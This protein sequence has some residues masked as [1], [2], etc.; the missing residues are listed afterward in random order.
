M[1]FTDTFITDA[2]SEMFAQALAEQG[3][4]IWGRAMTSNMN[5]ESLQPSAINQLT[6]I[7]DDANPPQYRYTSSGVVSNAVISI[8]D[9]IASIYC[10]LTNEQYS[11]TANTFGVWAK[12]GS[13]EYRLAII[14]R[15]G[16][17]QPTIVNQYENGI[18][19]IFVDFSL[20]VSATQVT[21]LTVESP[22]YARAAALDEE[23]Q[24]RTQ[25]VDAL[26]STLTSKINDN[27]DRTVTTHSA[28]DSSVG[29]NQ[30]ILGTK[31]FD[32]TAT[33]TSGIR[34]KPSTNISGRTDA[35]KIDLNGTETHNY[36]QFN[37]VSSL[38]A[39]VPILIAPSINQE[40]SDLNIVAV[41]DED[42]TIATFHYAY[43]ED[44]SIHMMSTTVYDKFCIKSS[45]VN[46]YG[47][48]F[49]NNGYRWE[50]YGPDNNLVLSTVLLEGRGYELGADII[51]SNDITSSF[52]EATEQCI[53]TVDDG[54]EFKVTD[55]SFASNEYVMKYTLADGLRF[56]VNPTFNLGLRTQHI[57]PIYNDNNSKLGSTTTRWANAYLK[58]LDVNTSASFS[59]DITVT[60]GVK[61]QNNSNSPTVATLTSYSQLVSSDNYYGMKLSVTPFSGSIQELLKIYAIE[62]SISGYKKVLEVD[63]IK[64]LLNTLYGDD[65]GSLF[66]INISTTSTTSINIVRGNSY[67]NGQTVGNGQLTIKYNGTSTTASNSYEFAPLF[68]GTKTITS[69]STAI[70]TLAIRVK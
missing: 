45:S 36:I 34:V 11:G 6:D 39:P 22:W 54:R 68:Y 29:D 20:Q 31:R 44:H 46:N 66:E 25:A 52:I 61:I 19:K 64:G 35:F 12:I 42:Q 62:D 13:G 41:T 59:T 33:F 5:I 14:A 49:E 9:Q 38:G 21:S 4:I 17:A 57:D 63:N 37:P 65:I 2:G 60:G 3:R 43:D 50:V 58:N 53:I 48:T 16:T 23:I 55:F 28:S 67:K 69:S 51:D 1:L 30:I 7:I 40:K 26:D 47:Y 24:A 15:C 8:A 70:T 10:E 32:S 27:M 56:G 18:E